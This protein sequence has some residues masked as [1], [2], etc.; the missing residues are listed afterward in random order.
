MSKGKGKYSGF[1]VG[2]LF[3]FEQNV[4]VL[5]FKVLE[6]DYLLVFQEGLG[7]D[8][9]IQQEGV[10]KDL[11]IVILYQ[12]FEIQVVFFFFFKRVEII[13]YIYIVILFNYIGLGSEIVI[14]EKSGE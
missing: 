4:I 14:S 9:G 12:E 8:I 5:V 13:E 10:L 3:Y 11:R 2:L 6:F 7:L 1:E